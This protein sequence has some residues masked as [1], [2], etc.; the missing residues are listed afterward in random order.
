M[1]M[2]LIAIPPKI[3]VKFRS[4]LLHSLLSTA[5]LL[6]VGQHLEGLSD[7]IR[8]AEGR[9][10][11]EQRMIL[12]PLNMLILFATGT[13]G[14]LI[15]C[16]PH[17]HDADNDFEALWGHLV[18]VD[19]IQLE[20]HA[21]QAFRE[22]LIRVEIVKE[23]FELPR[24]VAGI[25]DLLMLGA[26]NYG[27]RWEVPFE[28][29]MSAEAFAELLL[30]GSALLDAILE[31]VDL[32]W[33]EIYQGQAT[34]DLAQQMRAITYHNSQDY[35]DTDFSNIFRAVTGRSVPEY[36]QQRL[37]KVQYI[38]MLPSCHLGAYITT[39]QLGK[40]M[41]IGFNA[42][43]VPTVKEGQQQKPAQVSVAALYPTL[44][45]LADETRLKIVIL[46]AEQEMN[47]GEIAEALDL[48]QSTASRHLTL[49]AKT[50][51]LAM[52]RDG[53]MRYYVLRSDVLKDIGER[54]GR[55]G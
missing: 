16:V 37:K 51:I 14:Y 24:D 44:K 21:Q 9:I 52:R 31:T 33:H 4:S 23:H 29:P 27:Q 50:E 18:Q 42:N 7:W 46:L 12:N 20:R 1:M 32:L 45:A 2:E 11:P 38:E 39:S 5:G 3:E 15:E 28:M 17:G 54:I 8:H 35:E 6:T 19:L 26:E 36:I 48:T 13:Q 55:L 10:T 49:L 43:L 30:D 40:R 53:A 22:Y 41:W 25:A 47:V 34:E